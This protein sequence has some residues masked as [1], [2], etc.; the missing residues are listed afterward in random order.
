MVRTGL[1]IGQQFGNPAAELTGLPLL[2]A[3]AG[4]FQRLL[5]TLAVE[6]LQQIIQR[7]HLEGAQREPVVG[8]HENDKQVGAWTHWYKAGNVQQTVTYQAGKRH[9]LFIAFFPTGQKQYEVMYHDAYRFETWKEPKRVGTVF[10][11]MPRRI[12]WEARIDVEEGI[13]RTVDWLR[14]RERIEIRAR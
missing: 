1:E 10:K 7:V 5:E 3:I 11:V 9:G 12:S 6:R 14:E 2:H 4:V 8:R 13:A